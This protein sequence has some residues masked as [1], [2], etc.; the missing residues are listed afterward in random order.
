MVIYAPLSLV[1]STLHKR[2]Q[3]LKQSWESGYEVTRVTSWQESVV[4]DYQDGG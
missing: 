2:S 1:F 4:T 3:E